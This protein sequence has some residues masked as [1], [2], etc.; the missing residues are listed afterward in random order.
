MNGNN[1]YVGVDSPTSVQVKHNTAQ[2]R[3]TLFWYC[4]SKDYFFWTDDI[5]L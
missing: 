2:V 5:N 4:T 1:K 3:T